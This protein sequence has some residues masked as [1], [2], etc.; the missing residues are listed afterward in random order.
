MKIQSKGQIQNHSQTLWI[1]S[2]YHDGVGKV[3]SATK[4][5]TCF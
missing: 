5:S 2:K 1:M 3:F 4:H